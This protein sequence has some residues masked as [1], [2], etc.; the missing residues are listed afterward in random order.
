MHSDRQIRWALFAAGF[1]LPVTALLLL[2]ATEAFAAEGEVT[3]GTQWWNQTKPE[4]KFQEFRDI[5]NGPFMDSFVLLDDFWKGHYAIV[6]VDALQNDQSTTALYRRP[7]WTASFQYTQMPHTFSRVARTPYTE[8]TRGVLTLPDSLQRANQEN[9]GAYT[10]TMTDLLRNAP[11]VPLGFRTDLSRARLKGR[12]GNG[13]QLDVR[14]VRRQREGTKAY[15][16]S[17]G[18][19]NAV[20]IT[21]PIHQNILQ[22]EARASYVRKR[23]ALEASAGVDAFENKVDALVFDNPRRYTDSPT[24]GS[25][26]GRTDLYPDNRTLRGSLQ[27]GIQLPR[28]TSFNAFIGISEIT[29]K[30]RWLRLTINSAILQPDSFPLPGTNTNGKAIVFT[31]DYRLTGTPVSHVAGTLRFRRHQ[32]DNNTPVHVIPGQVAYDQAW[33]P[34]AVSTHPIGFTNTVVGADVD[35]TP[36]KRVSLSGT[37]EHIRRERTFREVA[38]DNEWVLRA[39]ARV[40][41][42]AGLELEGGYGHGDRKLDHF[43][44]EDYQNASGTFV[45][46]P[47]LRRFD[48]GDRQQESA[49][50]SIGLSFKDRVQISG[51]YEYVRNKY[52]DRGLPSL[53]APFDPDT[54]ETQLGLR[55]QVRRNISADGAVQLS[56][57]VALNGGYGWVQLYSNQLSRESGATMARTDSTTWQARIKEW[58]VYAN[59]SL[60]WQAIPD[61]LSLIG[62]FEHDHSPGAFRLTNFRGTAID[63]PGV[64]YRRQGLGAE[65][66]Y[67]VDDGTSFGFRWAWEEFKARDYAAQDV[68]LLFP[69]TGASTALFLG[70]SVQDYH[71]HILGVLLQ[72]TF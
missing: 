32:Y 59:A 14:G 36:E 57:R 6:G 60:T 68:P 55:D 8:V 53:D 28:R 64:L 19:S 1:L 9:S 56:E 31:Q 47:A 71:A 30:D 65:V 48:V 44:E 54:N 63:L 66:W 39:R 49:H 38:L 62:T 40:R 21:E 18:F 61:R 52:H 4:A 26:R 72:R 10:S 45:E 11:R 2:A 16:G 15:G 23:V 5:P 34:G 42:R 3:F 37:A 20:E 7:R 69:V 46:Q 13:V 27:A 50:G 58:F 33:Q 22:G 12:L 43:E 70:D 41:P 24:A 17:F 29:Q 25:S 35:L 67:K 51:S